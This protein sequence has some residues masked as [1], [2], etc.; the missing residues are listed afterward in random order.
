VSRDCRGSRPS[1]MSLHRLPVLSL[2][3]ALASCASWLSPEC[4]C[5]RPE[6]PGEKSAGS[7]SDQRRML[8]EGY[9]MLHKDAF[10]ISS[11][12]GLLYVKRESDEFD[13]Y[14]TDVGEYGARLKDDL[15]RLA[16]AFPAVRIDLQ[17]LPEMERRK[18]LATGWDKFKDIAPVTGK[19][20]KEWERTLLISLVNG[21][22]QER[23]LC[24]E[25]GKEEPNAQLKK[26]LVEQQGA[27]TKLWERGEALL[28]RRYYK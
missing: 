14:V 20:G 25:M 28:E 27:M 23:H 17:P 9:S 16:K 5:P 19:S 6:K 13:R 12:R 10:T 1:Y 11:V 8:N 2:T 15:E 24:E 21:L 3:L 18:R 7:T 4:D 26:F 22:N